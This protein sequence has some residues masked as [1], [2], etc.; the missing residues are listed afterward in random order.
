MPAEQT[1]AEDQAVAPTVRPADDVLPETVPRPVRTLIWQA[2]LG[3][4]VGFLGIC[5]AIAFFL[6]ASGLR[7]DAATREAVLD[8]GEV[9]ALRVTTFTGAE[10]DGWVADTQALATGDYADE[11]ATLFDPTIR[12]GLAEAE[13]QSV[14]EVLNSF[15][16]EVDGD[17]AVVFAVMRQTYTSALQAQAISDELRMEI[18]LERV[19]GEWLAADVA[20]LGPSQI[21]PIDPGDG[22]TDPA[23]APDGQE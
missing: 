11:V 21:T 16:Q 18:G 3:L 20:V 15:V 17:R 14:G 7:T 4:G 2:R 9:V 12:Q 22:G 6:Q 1:P 10:I 19:E 5:L 8:A 13:V 23:A